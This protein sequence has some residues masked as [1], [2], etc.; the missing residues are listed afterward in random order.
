MSESSNGP[1]R[2]LSRRSVLPLGAAA[3]VA[4]VSLA[5]PGSAAPR[6]QA[7]RLLTATAGAGADVTAFGAVGDG[8]TDDTAAFNA[9]IASLGHGG[10]VFVPAGLYLID[11]SQ[12][13]VLTQGLTLCGEGD[14]ASV[15]VAKPVAGSVIRRDINPA[16]P[17]AY[18]SDV[19]IQ[20][21]GIVLNHPATAASSNYV[22][23]GFDF[24]SV[25]RSTIQE[26]YV[27]NYARGGLNKPDPAQVDAIQG[28]GIVFG[29]LAGAN[30]AYAGGE[31]NSVVR[32]TI[33]GARKAVILD[34]ATLSP[35]SAAHATLVDACDIQIC[36][37]GVGSESQYTAGCVWRANIVQAVQNARGSSAMTTCYELNGYNN[38]ISGGYIEAAQA[39]QNV[40]LGPQSKCNRVTLGVQTPG[41]STDQGTGNRVEYLDLNND[42]VFYVTQNKVRQQFAWAKFTGPGVVSG[43]GAVA[44][45][46]RLA[47]GRYELVWDPAFPNIEYAITGTVNA[48]TSGPGVV[49]VESQAADRAVVRTYVLAS[50]G[51]ALADFTSVSVR[52]ELT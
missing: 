10:V 27:G 38:E 4:A 6:P 52:A 22:Q 19:L 47:A 25:T 50:T 45:V 28:Y 1:R 13:I 34:D 48:G 24:R 32:C 33:W 42:N 51:P 23:I 15:L 20:S 46:T 39:Q 16:G 11:P 30:P 9:A 43:S 40:F 18:L 37:I 36:E 21:I 31:V 2:G 5:V 17:N 26:C 8:V 49:V 14:D 3:A 44:S 29:T 7:G 35:L 12:G 41:P